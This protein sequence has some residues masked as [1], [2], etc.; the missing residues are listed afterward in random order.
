MKFTRYFTIIMFA[1]IGLS[2]LFTI[3]LSL[4]GVEIPMWGNIIIGMV[5]MAIIL[6]TSKSF[7]EDRESAR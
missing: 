5:S 4:L 3:I 2:S 1:S 6:W 7:C